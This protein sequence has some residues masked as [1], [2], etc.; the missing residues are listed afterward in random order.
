[1]QQGDYIRLLFTVKNDKVVT[2]LRQSHSRAHGIRTQVN[3]YV[4]FFQ[5]AAQYFYR[6]LIGADQ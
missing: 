1:V 3:L 6:I 4:Q 5:D 2:L